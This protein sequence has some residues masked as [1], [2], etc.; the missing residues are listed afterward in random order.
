MILMKKCMNNNLNN[1]TIKE[2]DSKKEKQ[3]QLQ[4]VEK[5]IYLKPLREEQRSQKLVHNKAKNNKTD[6]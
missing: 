6:K 5:N 3:G 2:L 4:E 1:L